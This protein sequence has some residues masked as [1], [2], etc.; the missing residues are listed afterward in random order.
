MPSVFCDVN[1]PEFVQ[2]N[3]GIE[4][5]GIIALG[6]I[7]GSEEPTLANLREAS[8]WTSKLS[9][10]PQLY[11]VINDTK[12]SY[13]GG[14][15]VEQPG[16]GRRSVLRTGADHEA[17]V[18]VLGVEDNYQFMGAVN[19]NL[20]WKVVFVTNSGIA[21]YAI[22]VSIYAKPVIEEDIKVP[23]RWDFN[24]KWSDDLSNPQQFT[25]PATIF[26]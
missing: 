13:T 6:L 20:D 7:K 2:N 3:C 25:A 23:L 15:P 18:S 14:T 22:D 1:V 19:Q 24:F 8:F 26:G 10:S 5:A 17:N 4:Q 16:Y 12:G 21:F 11:F 9:A